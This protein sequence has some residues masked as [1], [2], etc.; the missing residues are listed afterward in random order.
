MITTLMYQSHSASFIRVN[1]HRQLHEK[2]SLWIEL[3]DDL[4][5][6]ENLTDAATPRS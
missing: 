3:V 1:M 4:W 6:S 5:E 2:L